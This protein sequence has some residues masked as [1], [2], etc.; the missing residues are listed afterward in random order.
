MLVAVVTEKYDENNLL[1]SIINYRTNHLL[2]IFSFSCFFFMKEAKIRENLILLP[3]YDCCLKVESYGIFT[4]AHCR[5]ID[6]LIIRRKV[7]NI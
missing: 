3:I 7:T 6:T 2:L 1:L 4:S 5:F